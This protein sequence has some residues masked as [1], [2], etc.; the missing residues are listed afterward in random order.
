[1][2]LASPH[3]SKLPSF[4]D[5]IADGDIG[6]RLGRAFARAKRFLDDNVTSDLL[7]LAIQADQARDAISGMVHGVNHLGFLA[8]RRG[9]LDVIEGAARDAGFGVDQ[10]CFPSKI[11][12]AELGLLVGRSEVPTTVFVARGTTPDGTRVGVEA[13]VPSD[14]IEDD[15]V[16]RFIEDEVGTHF[17]LL[18]KSP[19][20][21]REAVKLLEAEGFRIPRFLE[22][23]P[24]RNAAHRV[25]VM[26]LDRHR[27]GRRLRL[28]LL[29]FSDEA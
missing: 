12:A 4:R 15:V 22:Q 21:L 11:F 6:V 24:V 13:F 17:A 28:E 27:A 18:L 9:T 26:Y 23:G 1:M 14:A 5:V 2:T 3:H 19:G 10:V 8:P 25:T 20:L 16:A 7:E 29:W